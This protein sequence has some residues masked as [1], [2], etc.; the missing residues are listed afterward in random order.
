MLLVFF[1]G[2]IF[3]A[4]SPRYLSED[5]RHILSGREISTVYLFKAEVQLYA[6]PEVYKCISLN[7]C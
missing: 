3:A 6:N 2:Q 7:V 4:S 1:P 5:I